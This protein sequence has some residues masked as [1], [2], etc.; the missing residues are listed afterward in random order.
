M[1]DL[2]NF[3]SNMRIG[4]DPYEGYTYDEWLAANPIPEKWMRRLE[5]DEDD[6]L[7]KRKAK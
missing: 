1:F 3:Y 4:V 5:K 7:L 6:L 2:E